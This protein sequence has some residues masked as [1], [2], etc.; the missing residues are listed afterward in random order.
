MATAIS[1]IFKDDKGNP[2]Q[3]IYDIL[4]T[5][6]ISL[7]TCINPISAGINSIILFTSK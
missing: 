2:S 5:Y 1:N 6:S 4:R 3:T 7:I